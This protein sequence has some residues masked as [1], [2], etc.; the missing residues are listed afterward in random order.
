MKVALNEKVDK[1]GPKILFP[2][3]Y[4]LTLPGLNKSSTEQCKDKGFPN[5][6][7]VS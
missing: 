3:A 2:P 5:I 4:H 7:S 6:T 1:E